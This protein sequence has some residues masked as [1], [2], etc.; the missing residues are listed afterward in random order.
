MR[1]ATEHHGA[2]GSSTGHAKERV[3][4]RTIAM[5]V[6]ALALMVAAPVGSAFADDLDVLN[7]Q[8]VN[9]PSDIALNLR[10]ARLA[11][12]QGKP[13]LALAAYER[14]VAL[15]PRNGEALAGL[16]RVRIAIKPDLTQIFTTAGAVYETNPLHVSSGADGEF[17][18]LLGFTVKDERRLGSSRWQSLI[19]GIG[20]WHFEQD[21]LNYGYLGF[22]TGPLASLGPRTQ[23]HSALGASIAGLGSHLFYTQ[24][25]AA[26][27]LEVGA[28]GATQT[29][30]LRAGYRQYD[31]SFISEAGF[32]ADATAKLV[33]PDLE[34]GRTLIFSPWLRYSGIS[35][36]ILTEPIGEEVAPG[37][38][39]EGG[40]KIEGQQQLNSW[41][42]LAVNLTLSAR[43]YL[44]DVVPLTTTHRLDYLVAPGA[45][46]VFPRLIAGNT[47]L[48]LDYTYQLNNSNNDAHD[49][50]NHRLA[51]MLGSRF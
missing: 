43:Q 5:A 6:L 7:G 44:F 20:Q 13:R 50:N 30:R 16:N 21:Q 39:V 42:T 18:A 23:L 10:Y 25:L 28:A 48:R 35:G 29:A 14:I 11:E 32:F 47:D 1:M 45:S 17:Q 46:I 4:G 33:L 26:F 41:V 40:A 19:Q 38:Y 12:Q 15:D 36:S 3:W 8:I 24:A 34:S 22:L 49:S 31:P 9:N 37:R 27:T 2:G 51:L